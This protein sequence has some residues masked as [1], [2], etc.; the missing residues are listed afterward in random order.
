MPKITFQKAKEFLDNINSE[1]N[2][3]IIHHDD[4]DGFCSGILYYDWCKQKGAKVE[5][6]TYILNKSKIK[7]FGLEKFNK[8]ILTDITSEVVAGELNIVSD[9]QVLYLDHHP[10]KGVFP[11]EVLTFIIDDGKYI[12]SSRTAGELTE[13]KPFLALIGTITDAGHLYQEN[14]DY[15]NSHL[16]Q[17]GISLDD[18]KKNISSVISNTINYLD[19]NPNETFKLL[20]NLK[21]LEDVASL[22]V[23]ADKIEDEIQKFVEGYEKNKEKLGEVNFYYFEP[24]LSVKGAVTGIIS[25]RDLDEVYIFASPKKDGKHISLSARNAFKKINAIDL[26]KKG[27]LGLED[28]SA[29]G[30]VRAAGGMILTK[31]LEK[32]KQN[33]REFLK[34]KSS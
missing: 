29:G 28:S 2:V 7:D 19:K 34:T 22:R 20:K 3:A 6:F 23:Y 1:D 14:Q 10:E 26:L 18:F 33:V 12:P 25:H 31:D 11:K 30:H 13:L 21:S 16:K 15:I 9:K 32:F 4:G 8:I 27:T 24:K 5:E 17:L